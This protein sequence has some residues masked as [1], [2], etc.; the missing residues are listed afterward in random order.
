MKVSPDFY[1]RL[2]SIMAER[3]LT[4]TDVAHRINTSSSTLTRWR[5]GVKPQRNMLDI[6]A[7][8]LGVEMEWLALG[9]GPRV[10]EWTP[11]PRRPEIEHAAPNDRLMEMGYSS[12][13]PPPPNKELNALMAAMTV[14]EL[15]SMAERLHGDPHTLSR[16]LTAVRQRTSAQAQPVASYIQN[17]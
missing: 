3:G 4:Q 10:A 16:V 9:T 2:E 14:D 15:L 11:P 17:K 13:I 7:R 8:A 5:R 6:L 1:E 12:P